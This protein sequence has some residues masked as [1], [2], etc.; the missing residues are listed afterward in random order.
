MIQIILHS[1]N[2]PHELHQTGAHVSSDTWTIS[3]C[4]KKKIKA[5]EM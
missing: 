2:I 5:T 4:V 1:L 3:R